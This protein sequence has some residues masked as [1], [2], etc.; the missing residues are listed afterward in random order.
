MLLTP[1]FA[2]NMNEHCG[3]AGMMNLRIFHVLIS[4][5]AS[6]P[7]ALSPSRSILKETPVLLDLFSLVQQLLPRYTCF[8]PSSFTLPF[9]PICDGSVTSL[10]KAVS[11]CS[12]V[13][14]PYPVLT[15]Y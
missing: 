3:H 14:K 11:I 9:P 4:A 2:P 1:V 13:T 6:R 8:Q 15:G 7:P 10:S 5:A 12:P